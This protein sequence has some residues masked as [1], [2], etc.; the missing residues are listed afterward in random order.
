VGGL[1]VSNAGG[2]LPEI[3]SATGGCF[4][5]PGEWGPGAADE[6][7]RA[8]VLCC[9]RNVPHGRTERAEK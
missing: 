4:F 2:Y 8:S 6:R 1:F 9:M 5:C 3:P 7:H